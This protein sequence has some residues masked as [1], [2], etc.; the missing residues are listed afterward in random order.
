MTR[1]LSDAF[2]APAILAGWSRLLIDL[3]RGE[4]DPTLVMKLSDGSLIPGN[5]RIDE[6]EVARRIAAFHAPYHAAVA[7]ELDAMQVPCWFRCTVFT[8]VVEGLAAAL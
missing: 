1:A 3:N 5:A 8:P 6:A 7:A 2:G 4:D